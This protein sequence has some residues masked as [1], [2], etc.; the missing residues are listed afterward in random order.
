MKSGAEKFINKLENELIKFDLPLYHIITSQKNIE[1]LNSKFLKIGR[2]D[3]V[4]YYRFTIENFANFLFLWKGIKLIFPKTCS[5]YELR[6]LTKTLN[7]YLN[8]YN[9]YILEKSDKIVF[10]SKLSYNLHKH[11]IKFDKKINYNIIYNGAYANFSNKKTIFSSYSLV[12]TANFRPVKRLLDGIKLFNLIKKKIPGIK[13]HVIGVVDQ[14]SIRS[15]SKLNLDSVIF[16]ENLTETKMLE[17]YK[18]SSIGIS[19]S[20]FDPC[21]NS[22]IEMLSC[23]LPVVTT[24][25]SGAAEVLDFDENFVVKED[26]DLDFYEI[27][28]P[29][30]VPKINL[31]LWSNK[32]ISIFDNYQEMQRK[33]L[34][35]FEKNIDLKKIA[36]KYA[37]LILKE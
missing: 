4:A 8:R 2:L 17:I 36:I 10:Q 6:F 34:Y 37:N 25:R 21:P 14:I 26:V 9:K 15:I 19:P 7:N 13:L 12:I 11:F 22:V 16:H 20:F 33:T 5:N 1:N 31:D 32:I 28:T 18:N 27:H 23:G 3:G 35:Y 29:L 24:N 30:K